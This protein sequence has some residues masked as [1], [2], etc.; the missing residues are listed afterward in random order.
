[1]LSWTASCS[2][3]S[4]GSLKMLLECLATKRMKGERRGLSTSM[5]ALMP[6][7]MKM[8]PMMASKT[9]PRILGARYSSISLECILKSLAKVNLRNFCESS[10]CVMPEFSFSFFC[11]LRSSHHSSLLR[12]SPPPPPFS[13]PT[14]CA[15]PSTIC[16]ARWS[17]G[18]AALGSRIWFLEMR[19]YSCRPKRHMSWARKLFFVSMLLAW[20]ASKGWKSSLVMYCFVSLSSM[21]YFSN[22]VSLIRFELAM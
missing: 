14:Y 1:M 22:M 17:V 18:A 11:R 10:N 20:W 15:F 7:S 4:L 3:S 21:L 19:M 16:W 6:P 12:S 8:A 2:K 5:T 13:L 9:S